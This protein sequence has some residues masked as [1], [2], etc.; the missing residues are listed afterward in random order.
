LDALNRKSTQVKAELAKAEALVDA[1]LTANGTWS[2][3][4]RKT[5]DREDYET[6]L[7][8]SRIVAAAL[9]GV[10]TSEMVKRKYSLPVPV[11]I[12]DLNASRSSATRTPPARAPSP[13][14]EDDS[15]A[16]LS[17]SCEMRKAMETV[18]R[19]LRVA[20]GNDDDA[21][22]GQLVAQADLIASACQLCSELVDEALRCSDLLKLTRHE[23]GDAEQLL[24][25][26]FVWG[27]DTTYTQAQVTRLKAELATDM[28]TADDASRLSA[29]A[30]E[31]V[32]AYERA[33]AKWRELDQ[34]TVAQ[35]KY[36]SALKKSHDAAVALR[37]IPVW[38]ARLKAYRAPQLVREPSES[39][40][41]RSLVS[42]PKQRE[43][44]R[45]P[46]PYRDVTA[47]PDFA[48]VFAPPRAIAPALVSERRR[49]HG[50]V[51]LA[52]RGHRHRLDYRQRYDVSHHPLL[53]LLR[54]QS[55]RWCL[56]HHRYRSSVLHPSHSMSV[57]SSC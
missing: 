38:L 46:T 30:K 15:D 18:E 55:L 56:R 23:L 45:T 6:A 54:L 4:D 19:D 39:Q 49:F 48:D 36:D 27:H 28:Q 14:E 43:H 29:R 57:S 50:G 51:R 33:F 12:H 24:G 1:Y 52:H 11:S 9:S 16:D 32:T 7:N 3:L 40:H 8:N 20:R 25:K 22:G 37:D 42:G 17:D 26:R 2:N 47:P 13:A 34:S 53:L 44:A 10:P 35:P 31:L 41:S 21:D 5:V